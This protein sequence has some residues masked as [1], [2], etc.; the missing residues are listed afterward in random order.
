MAENTV[1]E[2][3]MEGEVE[4]L[5]SAFE[6]GDVSRA[7]DTYR[8]Y[9]GKVRQLPQNLQFSYAVSAARVANQFEIRRRG[10]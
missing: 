9:L 3:M 7:F 6:T 1:N 10:Q 8:L 2:R 4:R 5:E